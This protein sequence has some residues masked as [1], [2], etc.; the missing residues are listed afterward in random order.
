[1]ASEYVLTLPELTMQNLEWCNVPEVATLSMVNTTLAR[2]GEK[3]MQARVRRLMLALLG[4]DSKRYDV[5][6]I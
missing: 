6:T 4:N 5:Q 2:A 3:H 1:M